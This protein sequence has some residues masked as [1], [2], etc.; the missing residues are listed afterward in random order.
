MWV[1]DIGGDLI[2]LDFALSIYLQ[3]NKVVANYENAD[4]AT[5]YS[6]DHDACV[7]YMESIAEKLKVVSV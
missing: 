7:L 2:N 3:L 6:G 1:Y 5:L 4:S